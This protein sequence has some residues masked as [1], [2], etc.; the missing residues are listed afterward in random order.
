MP[1]QKR[2]AANRANAQRSTGPRSGAGK[3]RSRFNALRHGLAIHSSV[4]PEF[5]HYV[6]ELARVL[7][8]KAKDNP[9]VLVRAQ[10]V[11]EAAID[12]LRAR[13][14]RVELMR[15]VDLASGHAISESWLPVGDAMP[16]SGVFQP[17]KQ[18]KLLDGLKRAL[19]VAQQQLK[20]PEPPRREN[21]MQD[22][23]NNMSWCE[24][25]DRMERLERYERRALSR[26]NRALKEFD[27]MKT[28]SLSI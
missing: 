23:L 24:I 8:G 7:A 5:Q 16:V 26:R 19:G 4:H 1:S 13:S 20:L 27:F 2:I 14:A 3:S 12:V 9:V 28:K 6:N 11:A 21:L 10:R 25:T 17:H 18:A 22:T 15:R